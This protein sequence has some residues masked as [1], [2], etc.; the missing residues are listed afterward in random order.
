MFEIE[1]NEDFSSRIFVNAKKGIA[2]M[3]VVLNPLK[4]HRTVLISE[5]ILIPKRSGFGIDKN[6]NYILPPELNSPMTTREVIEQQV[7]IMINIK[8][9]CVDRFMDIM[10]MS[11]NSGLT[12]DDI[13]C[14]IGYIEL[15]TTFEDEKASRY[16]DDRKLGL[17]LFFNAEIKQLK[18]NW[19]SA[20]IGNYRHERVGVYQKE[21]AAVR[22]EYKLWKDRIVKVFGSRK[23]DK[24]PI[25]LVNG[26]MNFLG[27]RSSQIAEIH[28]GIPKLEITNEGVREEVLKML[29]GAR[30]KWNWRKKHE[31]VADLLNNR[32]VKVTRYNKGILKFLTK[33]GLLWGGM[34]RRTGK[35]ILRMEYFINK[36]ANSEGIDSQVS[37]L[38]RNSLCP[39]ASLPQIFYTNQGDG[40]E[41]PAK[42]P[43]VDIVSQRSSSP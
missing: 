42:P 18:D 43:M 28:S 34:N 38:T 36:S 22:I 23:V 24:D 19:I 20:R 17:A 39:K 32:Y 7:R 41:Q 25:E 33:K 9:Q 10:R 6:T 37:R 15:A 1:K 2:S 27:K 11:S 8:S 40:N 13:R 35:R 16:V 14:N 12:K 26:I 31:F 30:C 3:G 21:E 29:N 5:G 4:T